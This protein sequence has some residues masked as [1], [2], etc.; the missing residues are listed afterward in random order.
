MNVNTTSPSATT[1]P[2][3]MEGWHVL[4]ATDIEGMPAS[5]GTPQCTGDSED[6]APASDERNLAEKLADIISEI[7]KMKGER[8]IHKL[9]IDDLY[10][11]HLLTENRIE[12]SG[13]SLAAILKHMDRHLVPKKKKTWCLATDQQYRICSVTHSAWLT[14]HSMLCYAMLCYAMYAI[15]PRETPPP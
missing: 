6:A 15:M 1:T 7:D 8:N 2:S 11:Q 3:E 5:D 13:N 4:D 10:S 12:N 9:M 14:L